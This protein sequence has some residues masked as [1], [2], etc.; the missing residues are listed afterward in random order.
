LKS[1]GVT[2]HS[3]L[4]PISRNS[5]QRLLITAD[6]NPIWTNT[7]PKEWFSPKPE[8]VI[9]ELRKSGFQR[10]RKTTFRSHLIMKADAARSWLKGAEVKASFHEKHKTQLNREG[11]EVPDWIIVSGSKS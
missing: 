9:E 10:I 4:S 3:F 11:L 5:R 6:S 1:G 7:P 8:L 2:I